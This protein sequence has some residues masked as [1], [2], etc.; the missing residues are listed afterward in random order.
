MKKYVYTD[1]QTKSR[2]VQ[3]DNVVFEC[4]AANIAEADAAFLAATGL[5]AAKLFNVGCEVRDAQ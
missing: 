3:I 4:L 1:H 5:V 2:F